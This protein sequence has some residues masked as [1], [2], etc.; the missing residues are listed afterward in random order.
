MKNSERSDWETIDDLKRRHLDQTL[1]DWCTGDILTKGFRRYE[2]PA[3]FAICEIIDDILETEHIP[4]GDPKFRKSRAG[5]MP[6]TSLKWIADQADLTWGEAKTCSVK[7]L[8]DEVSRINQ[9][10]HASA[11]GV[12]LV[13]IALEAFDGGIE[14][15][16]KAREWSRYKWL[17]PLAIGTS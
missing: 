7:Q 12:T 13:D 11:K 9:V 2:S 1:A 15:K 5:W 4:I 3:E 16:N 14:A 8:T 17:T 6:A 10:N